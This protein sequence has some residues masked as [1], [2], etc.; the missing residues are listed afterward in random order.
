M[1]VFRCSPI[2]CLGPKRKVPP[3]CAVQDLPRIDICVISHDHCMPQ[4]SSGL[5]AD[6]HLDV[7]TLLQLEMVQ[8]QT[9]YHVPSGVKRLLTRIGIAEERVCEQVWWEEACLPLDQVS[10]K[11]TPATYLP[12]SELYGRRSKVSDLETDS[13]GPSTPSPP[14]SPM[15]PQSLRLICLP[16]QHNSGRHLWGKNR[17]L[18]ATWLL[19]WEMPD[20][21]PFRCF[22]GG[23]VVCS[24]G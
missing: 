1:T 9:R 12:L 8:G 15:K 2:S 20:G 14:L 10:Q 21:F 6:D 17:T 19:I 13:L 24:S 22:F 11:E 7:P 23:Y 3:P 5:T 16:A 4:A 18:W